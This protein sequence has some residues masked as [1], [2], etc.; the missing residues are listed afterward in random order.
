MFFARAVLLQ[1][2]EKL[3]KIV[4]VVPEICS[5]T[6]RQTDRHTH[7]RAHHNTSPP[8]P[9]ANYNKPVIEMYRYTDTNRCYFCHSE[10]ISVFLTLTPIETLPT[11][12]T[13]TSPAMGTCP[14]DFQQLFFSVHLRAAQS[15]TAALVLLPL[16]TFVFCF[17]VVQ[18][19]LHEPY[20]TNNFH[21]VLCPPLHK[22]LTTP[23]LRRHLALLNL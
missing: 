7:R 2:T 22:S 10:A 8:L 16:L 6:D 17:A 18:S 3:V 21:V 23:L 12:P 15:L 14:L 20:E 1:T 19:Q 11:I 4:R 13:L 5:R 9:L